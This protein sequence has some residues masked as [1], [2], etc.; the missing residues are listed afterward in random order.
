MAVSTALAVFAIVGAGFCYHRIRK[1]SKASEDVEYPA[2]GVTGPGARTGETSPTDRKLAQNAQMYHYQ[3]Q[4]QQMI[5]FDQASSASAAG[6]GDKC[7]RASVSSAAAA[8]VAAKL[9]AESDDDDEHEDEG[10]YTVYECPGLAPVSMKRFLPSSV[11]FGTLTCKLFVS[12]AY[13]WNFYFR[14]AKWRFTIR[15]SGKT[16]RPIPRPK[17]KQLK[18][19]E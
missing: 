5:A 3:H 9:D 2:Y 17:S 12:F 11:P 6:P 10:D 13:I 15:S 16:M 14:P 4:K 8:A 19:H 1:N 18:G 7:E